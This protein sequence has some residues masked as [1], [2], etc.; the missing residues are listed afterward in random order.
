ML[1]DILATVKPDTVLD[2]G[3]GRGYNTSALDIPT[4]R[5]VA[6]DPD[7]ALIPRWR[8]RVDG[9][10]VRFC[11]MDGT[12]LAFADNTF[13][14]AFESHALHHTAK[15]K[16]VIEEM[17]RVAARHVVIE[18]PIDDLRSVE[19]RNAFAA[20]RLFLELQQEVGY[21]HYQHLAAEDM[22]S[23]IQTK[24]S[25]VDVQTE[26]RDTRIAFEEFF[27]SFDRFAARSTRE[28]YWQDR[29]ASFRASLGPQGLCEDDRL[30][31][32]A[33]MQPG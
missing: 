20:Q 25:A 16:Q 15:W 28:A 17:V 6:A 8:E 22:I 27:G 14:L 30:L 3:C 19:K 32:V 4:A 2:V 5:I 18:E 21:P 1:R 13:A 12:S 11:C 33:T 23:Y 24:A 31:I 7:L 29:L 9:S 10:T 26:K